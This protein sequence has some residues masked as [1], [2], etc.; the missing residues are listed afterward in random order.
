VNARIALFVPFKILNGKKLGPTDQ[1]IED[2][3]HASG[4]GLN[5]GRDYM[6]S[7]TYGWPVG[8][9]TYFNDTTAYPPFPVH[10][11]DNNLYN[12]AATTFNQ[13]TGV[14]DS[15]VNVVLYDGMPP[16][17]AGST[18][19]VQGYM[20]LF[21]QAV[22]HNTKSDDVYAVVTQIGACGGGIT[23]GGTTT[24]ATSSGGAFIPIRL[25]RQN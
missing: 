15:Q 25:I 10:G 20:S 13:A 14:S 1:G 11:G 16:S 7:P 8:S 3:I 18:V 6:C 5:Q 12:E 22:D 19:T 23:G 21:I 2:L 17:S 9:T 24:T 4:Q